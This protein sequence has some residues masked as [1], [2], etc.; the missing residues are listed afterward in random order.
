M[1]R[2]PYERTF[3]RAL[4]LLSYKP[5][6][7]AEMRARLLEKE[8][9]EESVVDQVISR[10]EELGYLN[11]EQ[12][13]ANFANSRLTAKPIGRTR[14]RHDL[15]RRKL[16]PETIENALD[17]A[18]EQKSEEELIKIAIDKRV[19]L[20]GAPTTREEAKKLFDYLIRR[21]FSYDLVLRKVRE[22]GKDADSSVEIE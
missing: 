1:A 13:A 21:G 12:F 8:W 7:L 5:R 22:A 6:S 10:L 4:N 18:Y 3:D 11:D 20:K 15:R 14:L 19:R 9:A 17:G 16:P 2:T